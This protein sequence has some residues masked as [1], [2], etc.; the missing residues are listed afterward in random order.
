[1]FSAEQI[2]QM[3]NLQPLEVEGGYYRETYRAG[4]TIP[5]AALPAR[6]SGPR[7][8]STAIYYLL[9]PQSCSRLLSAA[10]RASHL[11]ARWWFTLPRRTR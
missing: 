5:A 7:T 10:V 6:Y 1:M 3:L 11:R 8:F 9:T 4:Q 2:R